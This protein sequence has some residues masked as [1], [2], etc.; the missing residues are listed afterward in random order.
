M[1]LNVQ[2]TILYLMLFISVI[3]TIGPFYW[4]VVGATNISGDV[5]SIPPKFIPGTHLIDNFKNLTAEINIFRSLLN[6]TI[7]TVIY[8]FLCGLVSAPAGHPLAHFTFQVPRLFYSSF[9]SITIC[10]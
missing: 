4:M 3:L 8:T 5:L 6:S 7:V 2:K 1:M 10:P 9:H